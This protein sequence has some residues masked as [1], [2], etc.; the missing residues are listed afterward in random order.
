M[1][2]TEFYS[3][4]L[5]LFGEFKIKI[6]C[7][8]GKFLQTDEYC[9]VTDVYIKDEK[10]YFT[11][12]SYGEIFSDSEMCMETTGVFEIEAPNEF[13]VDMNHKILR[14]FDKLII[15]G[16][17]NI[18]NVDITSHLLSS[19]D[20]NIDV[21]TC[22]ETTKLEI[23]E[24]TDIITGNTNNL[25]NG[26]SDR[27]KLLFNSNHVNYYGYDTNVGISC[28]SNQDVTYRELLL[29]KSTL[30]S[31]YTTRSIINYNKQKQKQ[32]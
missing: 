18:E 21:D 24:I 4:L 29:K 10:I 13:H 28:E 16:I 14:C 22:I 5:N 27:E 8:D 6:D 12:E 11:V 32:C 19:V 20:V 1:K 2:Y 17:M 7:S 23:K 30:K 9:G 15:N 26:F 31:L 25:M 3:E